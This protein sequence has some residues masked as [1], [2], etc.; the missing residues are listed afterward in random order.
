MSDKIR[1]DEIRYEITN[2]EERYLN[3]QSEEY[4]DDT[5]KENKKKKAKIVKKIGDLYTEKTNLEEK[6]ITESDDQP[7]P[8]FRQK[9][10]TTAHVAWGLKK[11]KSYKRDKKRKSKKKGKREKKKKSQKK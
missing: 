9:G 1:I 10:R 11:R 7:P 4:L 8:M 6:L 3:Q 2:L 5:E